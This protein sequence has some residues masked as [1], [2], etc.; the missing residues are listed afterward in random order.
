MNR[1]AG[2][3][4]FGSPGTGTAPR[5]LFSINNR[6]GDAEVALSRIHHAAVALAAVCLLIVGMAGLLVLLYLGAWLDGE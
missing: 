5:A 2:F 1:G 6:K 4:A 3:P